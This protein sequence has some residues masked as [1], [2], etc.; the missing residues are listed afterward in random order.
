MNKLKL[1][2][3]RDNR[4]SKQVS[5]GYKSHGLLQKLS[6]T[7]I[8]KILVTCSYLFCETPQLFAPALASDR[9]LEVASELNSTMKASC[10][11]TLTLA[12]RGINGQF[13]S[14]DELSTSYIYQPPAMSAM[15]ADK[16]VNR[17]DYIFLLLFI[18]N[19]YSLSRPRNVKK[20]T[21]MRGR[22]IDYCFAS[23]PTITLRA[24]LP[25]LVGA[26]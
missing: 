26:E 16:N 20:S 7:D 19:F 4:M 14:V 23:P 25:Y 5:P 3:R 22:Y 9:S 6:G 8:S 13:V 18:H 17:T 21:V 15:K 2:I 24:C 12:K 11:I 10:Q 1:S